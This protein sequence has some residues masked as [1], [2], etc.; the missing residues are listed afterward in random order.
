[1]N[2][3]R[4]TDFQKIKSFVGDIKEADLN[5]VESFVSDK[6]ALFMPVGGYCGYSI[7]KD[8]VHP[9][10]MFTV[11]FDDLSM[12]ELNAKIHTSKPD[13]TFYLRENRP[14]HELVSKRPSRFLALFI[15]KELLQET[16]FLNNCSLSEA[17]VSSLFQT[18]YRLIDS[19][20]AFTEETKTDLPGKADIINGIVLHTAHILIRMLFKIENDDPMNSET[21]TE[22][23]RI[24]QVIDYIYKNLSQ[25]ITVE[26]LASVAHLSPSHF[27]QV[28]RRET[29]ESPHR[30]LLITRLNQSQRLIKE[31]RLNLT[32]IA[33]ECGFSSSSHFATAF[34]K[35]FSVSPSDYKKKN[36]TAFLD[37]L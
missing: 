23:F 7:T 17:P 36:L 26:E 10:P 1:M 13:T 12:I 5:F 29:K 20:K 15:S 22:N 32:E 35:E 30:Y 25:K 33:Y 34:Q 6:M 28:F 24:N 31:G 21:I 3:P 11:H 37:K 14:H 18:P 2:K 9:A 4:S 27:S 16:A 19:L 8:H